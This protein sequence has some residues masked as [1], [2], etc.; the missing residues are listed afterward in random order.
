MKER[1]RSTP[2]LS[3]VVV[4]LLA[5]ACGFPQPGPASTPG[6]VST[7]EAQPTTEATPPP[8]TVLTMPP[9][10]AADSESI[11]YVPIRW[12]ELHAPDHP[13]CRRSDGTAFAGPLPATDPGAWRSSERLSWT[14][15]RTNDV[16]AGTGI[17]FWLQSYD[18]YC[19]EALAR[20]EG[21][22]DTLYSWSEVRADLQM[23]FPHAQF[24]DLSAD[25]LS[26]MR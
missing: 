26:R 3:L 15:A 25:R 14:I 4:G 5:L 10:P 21:D 13:E 24:Y 18:V 16:Y 19:T 6:S 2:L 7:P 17:Q 20:R 23:I 22:A 12:V 9:T 11:R 8:I 1:N